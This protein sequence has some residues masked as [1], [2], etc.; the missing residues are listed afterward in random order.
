[1]LLKIIVIGV[2]LVGAMAVIRDGS[3]LRDAGLLSRCNNLAFYELLGDAELMNSEMSR[4]GAVTAAE[5]RDVARETFSP[6]RSNTLYYFA[7]N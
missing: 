1:M 7:R 6:E 3:V 5:M 4:Y 2:L